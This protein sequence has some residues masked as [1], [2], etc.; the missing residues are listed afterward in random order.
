MVQN[1]LRK[2]AQWFWKGSWKW[3]GGGR[4]NGITSKRIFDVEMFSHL[5]ILTSPFIWGDSWSFLFS[6]F[7]VFVWSFYWG[8]GGFWWYLRRKSLLQKP[9]FKWYDTEWHGH[10]YGY[11]CGG[12]IFQN[13]VMHANIAKLWLWRCGSCGYI[14]GGRI[15]QSGGLHG[16]I[17]GWG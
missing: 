15:F 12:R 1:E 10:D 2:I 16:N 3:Y 9:N 4:E 7:S 13:R 17:S 11:T 14:G 5:K 8:L 6:F